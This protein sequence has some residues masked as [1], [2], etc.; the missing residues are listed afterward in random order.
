MMKLLIITLAV[1]AGLHRFLPSDA[2]PAEEKPS[3]KETVKERSDWHDST[4]GDIRNKPPPKNEKGGEKDDIPT[5][6]FKYWPEGRIPFTIA[7][8]VPVKIKELFVDAIDYYE[9]HTCIKWTPKKDDD[10]YW[11]QIQSSEPG[12]WGHIGLT[13]DIGEGEPQILNLSPDGCGHPQ[14][15]IHEMAHTVG[16]DHL[17]KRSDRNEYLRGKFWSSRS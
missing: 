2:K 8:D 14:L 13:D 6:T 1:A 12:C 10:Q 3:D 7:D 5:V 11:V 15:V 16:M 17:Q 4:M 9:H